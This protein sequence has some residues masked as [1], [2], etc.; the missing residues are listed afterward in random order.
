MNKEKEL[1]Q[2]KR[3]CVAELLN[4]KKLPIYVKLKKENN[5]KVITRVE[6]RPLAPLARGKSTKLLYLKKNIFYKS[7]II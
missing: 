7:L 1:N 4:K 6:T 5:T 3:Q 2:R